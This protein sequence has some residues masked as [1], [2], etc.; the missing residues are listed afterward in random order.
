MIP[1]VTV[2][3]AVTFILNIDLFLGTKNGL[4]LGICILFVIILLSF[5]GIFFAPP[6]TN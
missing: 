1:I 2:L 6:P 3:L 5:S 4:I